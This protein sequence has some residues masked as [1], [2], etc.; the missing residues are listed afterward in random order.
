[1]QE[2]TGEAL[3]PD[4]GR[5]VKLAVRVTAGSSSERYI[6]IWKRNYVPKKLKLAHT[7]SFCPLA[8]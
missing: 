2:S 5:T 6:Y 8:V 7:P 4:L 1:M 3:F